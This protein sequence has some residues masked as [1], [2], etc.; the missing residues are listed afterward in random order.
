MALPSVQ[1]MEA[2]IR[3]KARELGI[4]PDIAVRVARSEGLKEGTW[5]ATANLAYGRERSYGPFQLHVAPKGYRQ[6]MGN[7]FVKSTGLDPSD[8]RNWRQGV[9]FALNQAQRGGWSPWF[10]AKKI[11]VTGKMGIG[12]Q[13]GPAA[14]PPEPMPPRPTDTV[15]QPGGLLGPSEAMAPPPAVAD[16]SPS[17]E[18]D[19][20]LVPGSSKKWEAWGSVAQQ[21]AQ[22]GKE[23]EPPPFQWLTP[24]IVVSG[25]RYSPLKPG[26]GGLLG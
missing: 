5:Q 3:A 11:G 20:R 15:A 9:D 2:Y 23:E 21:L 14:A 16:Y 22:L 8:P 6:G 12:G 4:D 1:E 25:D 17:Q 19:D 18:P 10:G 7:D 26:I 13:P 24:G